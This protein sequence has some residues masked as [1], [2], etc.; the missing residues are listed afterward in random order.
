MSLCNPCENANK[1]P[2][3]L[4]TLVVGKIDSLNTAVYV[5]VQNNT[6]GGAPIRFDATSD[7]DGYVEFDLGLFEPMPNQSYEIWI[8]LTTAKN[9]SCKEDIQP[10][11]C[12]NPYITTTYTCFT[13]QFYYVDTEDLMRTY[14]VSQ[15]ITL[16]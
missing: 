16:A 1:L 10:A 6:L 9:L 5:Y 4:D 8:T 15:T 2:A 13:L 11:D 7:A 14:Y 3:C 12:D